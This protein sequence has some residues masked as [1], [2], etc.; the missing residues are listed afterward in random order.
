MFK[1]A[2]KGN[3]LIVLLIISLAIVGVIIYLQFH[4]AISTKNPNSSLSPIN[5]STKTNT[6]KQTKTFRSSNV[7]KLTIELPVDYQVTE[8]LGSVTI[9]SPKDEQIYIERNGTNFSNLQDYIKNSRNNIDIKLQN[10][11]YLRINGLEAVSGFI[12]G[13]KIY[14]ILAENVVYLISTK[15]SSLFTDLDQLAQSFRYTP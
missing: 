2:Q 5:Q 13:E 11:Q 10:R 12:D 6:T 7:M 8:R 1:T 9:L 14:F 4:P 15:N 3:V